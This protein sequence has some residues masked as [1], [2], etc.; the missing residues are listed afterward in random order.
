M[1]TNVKSKQSNRHSVK[2]DVSGSA[3]VEISSL[4][5]WSDWT[6]TEKHKIDLKEIIGFII[7]WRGDS[8]HIEVKT[9]EKITVFSIRYGEFYPFKN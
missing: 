3:F 7:H 4:Y 9:K 6:T 2:A 5:F 1:S 8:W